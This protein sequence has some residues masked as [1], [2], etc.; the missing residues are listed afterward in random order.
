MGAATNMA[1]SVGA[2]WALNGGRIDAGDVLLDGAIGGV[3]GVAGPAVARLRRGAASPSAVDLTSPER[4]VHI[5]DGDATGGGHRWP[6]RPGQDPFPPGWSDNRII[7]QVSDLATDP[8][9]F[10]DQTGPAGSFYTN[11]GNPARFTQRGIRDG[12]EFKVVYEPA[13]NEII[14]AYSPRG[15]ASRPWQLFQQTWYGAA[16][17]GYHGLAPGVSTLDRTEEGQ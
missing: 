7:N 6:G 3:T 13:T 12:V 16:D 2:Q 8:N 11:N 14:T 1:T 17:G 5:L 9:A 10:L 15:G 4:R